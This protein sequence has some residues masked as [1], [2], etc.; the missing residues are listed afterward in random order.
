M[1]LAVLNAGSATVKAAL[2]EVDGAQTRIRWRQSRDLD[3]AGGAR[4]A[5]AA[6]LESLG[7]QRDGIDAVGH[8]V[9]HG[10]NR[11]TEPV[12]VDASVEAAIEALSPL[13]PLH[14]P[15]ALEGL[16]VAREQLPDRPAV[17]VFDTAFHARRAPESLRYPLAWDLCEEL[18]LYRYGFHGIA[19][20]SLIESLAAA[21]RTGPDETCAVTLQ[22]GAGCSACAVENGGSIETSMGFSPL[23]GLPMATRSGDL[24]P[25][26]PLALLR[27]GHDAA[28]VE[29]LFTRRSGLLGMAGSADLREVL[30]AAA[31]AGGGAR[32]RVAV[33]LFVRRIVA[34][35][36]AYFTLLGGRGA[37]VFGGGI[38]THSAEIRRRVADGL[39]AWNVTLD[40]ARNAAG[41]PGRISVESSR[42][43]YVFETDEESQIAR[44][45][46]RLI[47]S[48]PL[49]R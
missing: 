42:P 24:D 16:R 7:S 37:L 44:S 19:H 29:D 4:A 21:E 27:R 1:L 2:V 47:E 13:A 26:I 5:F 36:G 25:G 45:A 9:V 8:R 39:A 22:L 18:G 28:Q 46:A 14:N 49:R 35:T 15:P 12:R 23:G 38:G 17:A 40:P 34:L 11:F 30:A 31:A 33:A 43:V 41:E 3:R 48:E 32:A 20:A 6:I 10:G